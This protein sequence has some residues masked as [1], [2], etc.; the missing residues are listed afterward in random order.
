MKTNIVIRLIFWLKV[1]SREQ[2]VYSLTSHSA[3]FVTRAPRS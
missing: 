1:I 2:I 3:I